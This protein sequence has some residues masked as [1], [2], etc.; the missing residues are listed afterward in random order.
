[1]TIFLVMKQILSML[2]LI[3]LLTLQPSSAADFNDY[4]P[5]D[6]MKEFAILREKIGR[7]PR[8]VASLNS[9][10]IIYARSNRVEDAVKIWQY[11]LNVDRRYV[12]LYNN[13]GS[14][15]KQ[16]GKRSEARIIFQTGLTISN[17]YWIHYNLG[18]LEKEEGNVVAARNC[19]KNALK[20]NPGFQP[21]QTKLSELGYNVTMPPMNRTTRPMSIGSYKPPVSFGNVDLQPLYPNGDWPE[22]TGNYP[23]VYGKSGNNNI[24]RPFVPLTLAS[25]TQIIKN[26]QAPAKDRFIALTFDDGPHGTYTPEILRI[27]EQNQVKATFFVLGNRAETYPDLIIQMISS[28]HAIGNHTWD[29]KSLAKS[30]SDQALASL[31]KTHELISGLTGQSSMIVRPPYGH[32]SPRVKKLI[33]DQGWHEVMWD[34]DS[35]DWENKNPDRILYRVMKSVAPG[36]IVLFHDIHPGAAGMLQTLISAFKANGYRFI[37]IPELI[38]IASSTS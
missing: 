25:C 29:H 6:L 34:S 32:T 12:H 3:L 27:L 23:S 14:A 13:L 15:L 5:P 17:S 1:M 8:D 19:F 24:A 36:S 2:A 22:A 7:N 9:M 37:T 30:S 38:E 4:S 11:A 28:G 18:L 35:R 26:F 20:L 33:H 31:R 21:A 16:L 10:G